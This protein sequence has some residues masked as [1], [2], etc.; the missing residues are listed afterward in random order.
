MF[1]AIA[2]VVLTGSLSQDGTLGTEACP[3]CIQ[4][5]V[6]ENLADIAFTVVD[7]DVADE[8]DVGVLVQPGNLTHVALVGYGGVRTRVRVDDNGEGQ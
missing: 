3:F 1:A 6:L 2:R 7:A 5:D 8:R 4:V